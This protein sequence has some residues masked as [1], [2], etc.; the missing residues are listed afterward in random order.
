MLPRLLKV[1]EQLQE[2]KWTYECINEFEV[3][4]TK[5]VIGSY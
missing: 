5:V 4:Q 2:H 3:T 1:K